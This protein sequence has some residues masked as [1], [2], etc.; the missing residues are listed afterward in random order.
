MNRVQCR[1]SA[2]STA[3][4]LAVASAAF[5]MVS[6]DVTIVNVALPTFTRQLGATLQQLQ[7]IVDGF[8]SFMPRCS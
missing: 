5:S 8:R 4:T 3:V 1:L 2:T 7:W 6:L